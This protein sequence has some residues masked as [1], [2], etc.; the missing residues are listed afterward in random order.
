MLFTAVHITEKKTN[1][2]RDSFC[3]FFSIL[4]FHSSFPTHY[5][6]Q[7]KQCKY[8]LTAYIKLIMCRQIYTQTISVSLYIILTSILCRLSLIFVRFCRA[9]TCIYIYMYI[10][11]VSGVVLASHISSRTLSR[12]QSNKW[13]KM[14]RN[15]VVAN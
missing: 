5:L 6:A 13:D 3:R 7:W 10:Y 2:K 14:N 12:A 8:L 15:D 4:Q 1:E 11:M 9:S